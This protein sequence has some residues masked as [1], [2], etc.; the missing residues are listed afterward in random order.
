MAVRIIIKQ[1]QQ[2]QR[3]DGSEL[4]P[5]ETATEVKKTVGCTEKAWNWQYL[6]L[7]YFRG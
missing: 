5:V 2:T 3:K 6:L 1:N 7:P 4:Q